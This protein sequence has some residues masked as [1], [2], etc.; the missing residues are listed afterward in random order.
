[1]NAQCEGEE[2][3]GWNE[4]SFGQVTTVCIGALEHLVLSRQMNDKL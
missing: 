2:D 3:V 1:M 4:I